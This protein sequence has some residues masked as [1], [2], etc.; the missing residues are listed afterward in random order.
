MCA[1]HK[2]MSIP[3]EGK[4]IASKLIIWSMAQE[5]TVGVVQIG[6]TRRKKVKVAQ[7]MA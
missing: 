6:V 5:T 4:R 1:E 3:S 2:V 7:L